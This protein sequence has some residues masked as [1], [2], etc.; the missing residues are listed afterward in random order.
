MIKSTSGLFL[1]VRHR[2]P[3]A[4]ALLA[5]LEL[6][7]QRIDDAVLLVIAGVLAGHVQ[8]LAVHQRS[9]RLGHLLR[10]VGRVAVLRR[11]RPQAVLLGHFELAERRPCPRRTARS[12]AAWPPPASRKPL[13]G[14]RRSAC[15][16]PTSADEG[17]V[18]S[19]ITI[20]TRPTTTNVIVFA[21]SVIAQTLRRL[22]DST[23]N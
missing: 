14:S 5:R 7:R 13:S 21:F 18:T 9:G 12:A 20:A 23:W 19:P 3:R 4:D 11:D 17:A 6:R 1:R 10:R 8:D 22:V 16:R 15:L 2:D